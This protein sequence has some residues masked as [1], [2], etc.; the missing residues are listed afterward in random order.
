[1]PNLKNLQNQES[2]E[3]ES[4][5]FLYAC[6]K[7]KTGHVILWS[8]ASVHR[9]IKFFVAGKLLLQFKS[10]QAETWYIVRP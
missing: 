5:Y 9:S 7:K 10:D 1:M 4:W 3:A 8:L 6:L 2:F